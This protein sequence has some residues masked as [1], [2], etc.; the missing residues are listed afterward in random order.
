M[1]AIAIY[2]IYIYFFGLQYNLFYYREFWRTSF[3]KEQKNKKSLKK[4]ISFILGIRENLNNA[5]IMPIL[6]DSKNDLKP[7]EKCEFN[8]VN[9]GF[10]EDEYC[11]DLAFEELNCK[12]ENVNH[13][14]YLICEEICTDQYGEPAEIEV[15]M[16]TSNLE[17]DIY[18]NIQNE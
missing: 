18:F 15:L 2:Y 13:T 6:M 10:N 14:L 1:V 5:K 4:P 17:I 8:H 9:D 12:S 16:L 3:N 11:F 7:A